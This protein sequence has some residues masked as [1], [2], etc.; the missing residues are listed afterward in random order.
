[1]NIQSKFDLKG[2]VAIVTGASK[3]I[4]KSIAEAL[5]QSGAKVIV[6]SRK[7]E[8]VDE[9]KNF[10]SGDPQK[11][12]T[13][14]GAV[15]RRQ[16][17]EILQQQVEDAVRKGAKVLIGGKKPEGKGNHFQPTVLVDVN[18]DMSVMKDESFGPVIGIQKVKYDDEAVKLMQYTEYG[19][20]AAVYSD[21][22][23]TADK[24]LKQIDAGTVYWNC[25]D[26]VSAN[27]PWSGRGHSGFGAT[28]S[29]IGIRAFVKPKA[30][31]LR[32]NS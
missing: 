7:Q 24:I 13:Y 32:G 10:K 12:D 22:K 21:H 25:C 11:E 1:M 3:G 31:H 30:Y 27:L 20:T 6:S 2:K 29:Y 14:I 19:L 28:L 26:R 18:H 5:G 9:V 4:G 8:A 23:E 17:V 16:Q 15:P